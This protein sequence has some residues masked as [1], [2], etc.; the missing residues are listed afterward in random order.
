MSVRVTL[1]RTSCLLIEHAGA[2]AITDPWFGRSMRG[3]PV[4]RKPGIPLDRLPRIDY[5]FASHLHPDHFD[6]GAVRRFGHDRM[7]VVGT[8]GTGFHCAKVGLL[9]RKIASV[10]EL[11]P[12]EAV[13]LEPFTVTATPCE[14][15]GPPPPEVNFVIQCGDLNVFFGGDCRFSD[16]FA[17]I[18][19]RSPPIDIALLPI[20]G[21]LIFGHRTTM[22]P[23]DAVDACRVLKPRYAVPIHEGGE[24]MS[25]PPASRHPGRRHHF[26]EALEASG[27][28]TEAVVLDP[29]EG[30]TFEA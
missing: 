23:R 13:T 4:F 26:A 6:R 19:E 3:L 10:H 11:S 20:G 25:V 24:W 14:H 9:P 30:R 15:T 21:T 22:D 2:T 29:G 8:V 1:L 27:L 17:Q 5:V 7:R 16:A 12:W 28:P 18:A